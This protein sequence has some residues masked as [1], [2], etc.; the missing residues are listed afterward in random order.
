MKKISTS[1]NV[2]IQSFTRGGFMKLNII[3]LTKS[4][5]KNIFFYQQNLMIDFDNQ[6]IAFITGENGTGKSTLM[7]IIS[8]ILMVD[9]GEFQI[10]SNVNYFKWSKENC[11]YMPATERG[12]T[13]KLT[14]RENIYYLCSLKG[15][16]K[17][18]ITN[19]L[20]YYTTLFDATEILDKRVEELSTGQKRKIHLLSAFCSNC[21][22]LLLDEPSVGLD[23]YNLGLLED[24]L[25]KINN[26]KKQKIILVSHDQDIKK[27]LMGEEIYV[28]KSKT[29]IMKGEGNL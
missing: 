1:R 5:R 2:Y 21:K 4:F 14:G 9:S 18:V 28:N 15:S 6:L 12:M 13:Y 11:Y 27:K 7:K 8:G 10:E 17:E 23:T 24:I 26:E 25:I 22:V 29:I 20:K 16:K 3:N 19:R